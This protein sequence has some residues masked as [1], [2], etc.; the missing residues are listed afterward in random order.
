MYDKTFTVKWTPKSD[1]KLQLQLVST[2]KSMLMIS[3]ELELLY[4]SL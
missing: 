3:W 2:N 1:D 4:L